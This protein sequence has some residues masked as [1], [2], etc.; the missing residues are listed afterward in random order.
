MIP[1]ELFTL[2]YFQLHLWVIMTPF[3]RLSRRELKD[4]YPVTN[5]YVGNEKQLDMRA[6]KQDFSSPALNVIYGLESPDDMV[7]ALNSLVSECLDRHAT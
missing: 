1:S 5:T 4:I 2:T 7:H 3:T 6:F